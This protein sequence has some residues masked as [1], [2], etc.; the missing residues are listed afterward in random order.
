MRTFQLNLRLHAVVSFELCMLVGIALLLI[1]APAYSQN[2]SD[3]KSRSAAE[4]SKMYD[5]L[6][7]ESNKNFQH[8]TDRYERRQDIERGIRQS[9]HK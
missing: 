3:Q 7:K 2:L 5:R 9:R 1:A 4:T 6:Y 8:E